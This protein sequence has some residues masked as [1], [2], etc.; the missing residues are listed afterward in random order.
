MRLFYIFFAFFFVIFYCSTYSQSVTQNK[1][2][3]EVSKFKI[4]ETKPT[5]YLEFSHLG[6]D[7]PWFVGD[8]KER[9]WLKM[10]NNTPNSIYIKKFTLKDNNQTGLY[11]LVEKVIKV[12]NG[13]L[14]EEVKILTNEFDSDIPKG[15]RRG[16]SPSPFSELLSGESIMF[17]IPNNH[18]TKDLRIR[19]EFKFDWEFLSNIDTSLYSEPKHSIFFSFYDLEQFQ[20]V[21]K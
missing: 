4:D 8:S 15:Y 20:R 21:K 9:V 12:N 3:K 1:I 5:V 13:P 19:I 18:I 7:K 17:S 2:K 10:V 6:T 14:I 11:Y 16:H